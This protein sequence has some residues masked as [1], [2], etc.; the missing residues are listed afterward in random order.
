[1]RIL[2]PTSDPA[3]VEP[4]AA[5]GAD[6]FYCGL[7]PRE[8]SVRFGAGTQLNRR[9]PGPANLK[10]FD[11]LAALAG[12]C[13]ARGKPLYL[14]LNAPYY[15]EAQHGWILDF[16]AE[17]H[18]S[19]TISAVIVSDPALL[20]EAIRCGVRVFVSTLGAAMNAETVA[21]YRDLGASRVI[22]SRHL[23]VTEIADIRRAVPDVELEVF[24][25]N[26]N[27]YF[28]E[29]FCSTA[30]ALPG[31]GVYCTTAFIREVM[32]SDGTGETP[33]SK[34]EEDAWQNL[35]AVRQ[36]FLDDLQSCILSAA[37]ARAPLSACAL[38]ALPALRAIGIDSVKIVGREAG[39]YRKLRSVQI[40]RA[41][42]ERAACGQ[43]D[44]ELKALAMR[45][46]GDLAA[47]V[48]GRYCYFRETRDPELVAA[49]GSVVQ[50]RSEIDQVN[51][52]LLELLERRAELASEVGAPKQKLGLPAHDERRQTETLAAVRSLSA[53]RL[54]PEAIDRVFAAIFA[55]SNGLSPPAAPQPAIR[56]G[57]LERG[58]Q[59]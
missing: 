3:E 48:A 43:A 54:S 29:A 11:A 4:L 21:F 51:R 50:L 19:A 15:D 55:E 31:A 18:R 8:W 9:P 13:N 57:D 20:H 17:V 16:L 12:A 37:G 32:R 14:T 47:C 59:S 45:A 10:S 36:R 23:R 38:C 49:A 52:R 35:A 40:V 25:L 22:L 24:A 1:M 26:D 28:E 30:H 42:L 27:C 41:V 56:P 5:N 53:G 46:R 7:V 39:L 2:A 44:R 6:E 58:E 34:S 33:L